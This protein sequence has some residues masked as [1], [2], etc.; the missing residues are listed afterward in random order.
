MVGQENQGISRIFTIKFDLIPVD[1]NN[2][3]GFIPYD[4]LFRGLFMDWISG[5]NRKLGSKLH[6]TDKPN[7]DKVT[8]KYSMWHEKVP[9][10]RK[11]SLNRRNL[12]DGEFYYRFHLNIVNNELMQTIIEHI[13]AED[14]G[15]IMLGHQNYLISQIKIET[16]DPKEMF[17]QSEPVKKISLRFETPTA[18][19][20]RDQKDLVKSPEPKHVFK[21]LMTQWH[22]IYKDTEIDSPSEL[23]D[24]I[25]ENVQIERQNT[26]ILTWEMGKKSTKF[27][28]FMG[29]IRYSV[30]SE[31]IQFQKWLDTLIKFGSYMSV[32]KGRTNGFGHFT[33][34]FIK[35]I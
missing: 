17:Q 31:N 3:Y 5:S 19:K 22:N 8:R 33:I 4:Y 25:N 21:N 18:F 24:W 7:L 23:F 1:G 32:G 30:R 20:K 10:G 13:M 27:T 12:R 9:F 15:K 35:Y 14:T 34:K 2:G 29:F 28:G 16:M 6:Q 11:T 26:R